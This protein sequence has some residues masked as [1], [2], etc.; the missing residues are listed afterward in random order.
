MTLLAAF[1]ILL[2]RHTNEDDLLVGSPIAGRNQV[3]VEGLI[4]FFVNTLVLRTNLAGNPTFRELLGRVREGAL[5][6]YAHQD[7]PFEKLVEELQPERSLS[8]T[9]LFQVLFNMLT[10]QDSRLAL[11]GI[12]SEVVSFPEAESK[13]DLTLYVREQL[14]G[15]HL[16]LVYN[17]DL[18]DQPR[19]LELLQQFRHLL[20]QVVAHP[21]ASIAEY[22]LVTP[23]AQAFLPDPT[24][25][26]PAPSGRHPALDA[27]YVA[28]RT[29][30]E[31]VLAG[32][33][34]DVLGLDRV[35]VEDNFF[36]LGGE[37]PVGHPDHLPAV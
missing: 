16:D 26:L 13:F 8:H 20:G 11:P 22:S 27:V 14:E 15:L 3:E 36:E 18:F 19:M 30:T 23:A 28:P 1:Q 35:G 9:P 29:P 17:A 10:L 34:A 25:A 5:G 2:H 33:W 6:A 37:L 4:G 24:L 31:E 21:Q 32:I 7:L 12:V